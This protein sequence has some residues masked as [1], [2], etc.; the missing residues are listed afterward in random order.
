MFINTQNLSIRGLW[1]NVI[2][3]KYLDLSI[4]DDGITMLGS[5]EE[6]DYLVQLK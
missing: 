3:K 5:L 6:Q 4:I 2:L 1:H